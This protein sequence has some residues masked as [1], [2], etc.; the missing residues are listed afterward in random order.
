VGVNVTFFPQHFLGLAGMPRRYSDYSDVFY[1]WNLVSRF[2]RYITAVRT[3]VF[4]YGIAYAFLYPQTILGHT[5]SEVHLEFVNS[6]YP[7][8]A[9][10]N[11]E[12]VQIFLPPLANAVKAGR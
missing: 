6:E 2:G 4:F 7:L 9:H 12:R 8:K 3:F 5:Y 10:T 11:T 1:A